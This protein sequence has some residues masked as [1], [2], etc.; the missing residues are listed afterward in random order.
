MEGLGA[1]PYIARSASEIAGGKPL[2]V[3]PSAIGMRENPYGEKPMD[4]P[5]NIRQAMNY[6]DPRQ[7]GLLGAAWNLAYFAHFAD[8]GAAAV[9]LGGLVGAFGVLHERMAW[10]QPW[11]DEAGGLYPVFHVL[12]GL[13]RLKG[14]RR[15]DSRNPAPYRLQALAGR[16]DEGT[17]L[18]LAN[19]T[20]SAIEVSLAATTIRATSLLDADSFVA[21]SEAADFMDRMNGGGEGSRLR[22]PPFAVMR[23]KTA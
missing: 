19:L 3:G 21:A 22:L 7:R 2:A 23:V 5:R 18:W 4:N 12:R 10:P 20:S 16:T 8:G 6:N 17:E 9:A 1:L 14:A 11:Y 15:L 13:A